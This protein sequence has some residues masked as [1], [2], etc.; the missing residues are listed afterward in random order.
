M[1]I[2]HAIYDDVGN[3]WLGG[4][5]AVRTHEIYSRIASKGNAAS[6]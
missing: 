1:R 4:G 6:Q 5:G 2:L 3:P